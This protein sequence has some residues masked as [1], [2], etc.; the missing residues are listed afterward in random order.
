[1]NNPDWW[2][3]YN[4]VKHDRTS[5]YKNGNLGKAIK[6]VAALGIIM[7]YIAGPADF[8]YTPVNF[9]GSFFSGL[10]LTRRMKQK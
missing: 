10:R 1:M 9:R 5:N 3:A 2:T 4:D 6:A 8:G 7:Q